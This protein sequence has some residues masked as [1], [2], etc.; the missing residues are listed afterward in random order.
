MRKI[1][2]ITEYD[3]RWSAIYRREKQKILASIGDK[4][5][6]IEHIGSTAVIGLAAKPVIDIMIAITDFSLT[7]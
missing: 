2:L 7:S 1:I 6:A 4:I 5:Q 3:C